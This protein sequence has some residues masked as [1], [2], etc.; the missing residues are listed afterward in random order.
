MYA[1]KCW[2]LNGLYGT[3]VLPTDPHFCEHICWQSPKGFTKW[4]RCIFFGAMLPRDSLIWMKYFQ[5]CHFPGRMI[6]FTALKLEKMFHYRP[7]V[8]LFSPETFILFIPPT[9]SVCG[10]V[11]C[12]HVVRLS[13]CPS[14][15]LCFFLLSWK[16]S[17]GYSSISA[18][19]LI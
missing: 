9:N 16:R 12:F 18:D 10:G 14:V 3:F 8:V 13:V 2:S 5:I 1:T 15:T 17:D 7:K 19:T 11:Y 4:E 6:E